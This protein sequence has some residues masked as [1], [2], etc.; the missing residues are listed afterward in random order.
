M[1]GVFDSEVNER[2]IAA[3]G[4]WSPPESG[5][6]PWGR[7][8]GSVPASRF[9]RGFV[10]AVGGSMSCASFFSSVFGHLINVC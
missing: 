1:L 2:L 9:L 4:H 10:A 8:P 6:A 3:G 5:Q 7:E